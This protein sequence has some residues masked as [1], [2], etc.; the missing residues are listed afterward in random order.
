MGTT[1][2]YSPYSTVVSIRPVF[3]DQS[4][5][6]RIVLSSYSNVDDATVVGPIVVKMGKVLF[7]L[8]IVHRIFK[9]TPIDEYQTVR[10]AK[11]SFFLF[12]PL[13]LL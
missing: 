6:K 2:V 13:R 8:I 9:I 12:M 10:M 7:F 3:P 4:N 11:E 1:T 5:G